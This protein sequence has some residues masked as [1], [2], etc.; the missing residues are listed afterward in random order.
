MD[1]CDSCKDKALPVVSVV[2]RFGFNWCGKNECLDKIMPM[3]RQNLEKLGSSV[4]AELLPEV[5]K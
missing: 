3:I 1:W 2:N 5:K 4:K